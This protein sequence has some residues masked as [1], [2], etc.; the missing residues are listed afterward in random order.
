MRD[1]LVE[2]FGKLV[3]DLDSS[4][5][6]VMKNEVE[7]LL[8]ALMSIIS[9]L[10]VETYAPDT[11]LCVEG[12]EED[13]FY[14]IA[15]GEVAIYKQ[16]AE[17]DQKDLLA[18]KGPGDFFGEMALVLNAP[19]SA[20]VITTK[21]S[22]MLELDRRAFRKATRI[23]ERLANLMS[24]RTIEQLDEN[25]HKEHYKRG[26]KRLPSF[27]IFTSY[28]RRD[29]EFA[30]KLVQDLQ[31]KLNDNNV[32][33]WID[34][35]NIRPGEEWDKIIEKA[36]HTCEAMLLVLSTNS[37]ESDNVRDE[38]TF[39]RDEGKAIIPVMKEKC[40]LPYRVRRY[41]YLDFYQETYTNAL[42]QAHA[43][44]LELV[45]QS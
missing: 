39:Y 29:E 2:V 21:E 12:A 19:R 22:L 38:W 18:H 32:T 24:Q 23:S 25:W 33:I 41:Q 27:H 37:I 1:I 20:D 7:D 8:Q 5:L 26:Q 36:L 31:S 40:K 14:I 16:L 28:S 30:L 45:D 13:K 34:Q 6:G 15:K 11:K 44:I 3:S 43:R 17:G 9:Q 42:A 10:K 35:L 4:D